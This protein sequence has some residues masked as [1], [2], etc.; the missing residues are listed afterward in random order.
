MILLA[1]S[2][3][4]QPALQHQI[5]AIAADAHG[6]VSVACALPGSSLNCDW[7]PHAHPPMQS[8]FKTPL[9]LTVLHMVEQGKW[10]FDE[11][12]RFRASDRI[13]PKTVSPLQDKYPA[14]EVEIPLG[15]LLRLTVLEAD[16][17]AADILLRTIGGPDVVNEYL[18]SLGI[19]GFHL[20]DDEA[21][22]DRKPA[23][24]YRN[25]FEPA[26]A[27]QLLL[28]L[29]DHSPLTGEHTAMLL[30]WM[31]D[32]PRGPNRIKGGLPPGTIVMHKPGTSGTANGLTAAWNDIGLIVLPDGRK[33]A[34]AIFVTDSKADD[35]TRDAV[36]AR[37]ARTFYDTAVREP[38]PRP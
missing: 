27:V 16:N 31:R 19:R 14:G 29:C 6:K 26:A 3:F 2:G 25:W 33:L 7:N 22:L 28:R 5:A 37:I 20:Q 30:A 18:A 32:T 11:P 9:A 24:M 35:A 4:A 21:A 8:V 38:G 10:T 23:L 34:L 13:L 36:V 1:A 12:I 15:E 17:V